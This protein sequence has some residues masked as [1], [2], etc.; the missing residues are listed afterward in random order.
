L[1]RGLTSVEIMRVT[2]F[3][4]VGSQLISLAFVTENSL[5]HLTIHL[6]VITLVTKAL[7]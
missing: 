4:P 2:G 7:L 1:P 3:Y 5:T 6:K